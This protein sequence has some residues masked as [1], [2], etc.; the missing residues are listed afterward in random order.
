MKDFTEGKKLTY[1][2]K[3]EGVGTIKVYGELD[4]EKLIKMLLETK[5][6]KGNTK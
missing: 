4:M 6:I 1:E 5:Y 2:G 3:V